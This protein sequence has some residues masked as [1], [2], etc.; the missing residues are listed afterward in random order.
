MLVKVTGLG[1][2]DHKEVGRREKA[3][4]LWEGQAAGWTGVWA[5]PWG[6]DLMLLPHFPLPA[7]VESTGYTPPLLPDGDNPA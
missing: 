4:R 7:T 3:G 2:L 6:V 5:S 1:C